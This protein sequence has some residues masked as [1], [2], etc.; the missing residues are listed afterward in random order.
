VTK[1]AAID[2]G[3]NSVRL[4]ITDQ[5]GNELVRSMQITRLGQGVDQTGA[6]DRA[7]MDRTLDVLREYGQQM[8]RSEVERTRVVAT[9][10]ARDASNRAAFFQAVAEC[11]HSEPELLSGAEEARLS[12]MGAV[13][14]F[15]L[16]LAPFVSFDIGGGSTEF[17]MGTTTP[18]AWLS[19]DMGCVRMSE[20]HLPS[21]PP[22]ALEL[23]RAADDV[24]RQLDRVSR[25]L[26]PDP[27]HTW[28]GLAGT[29]TSLAALAAG[30]EHYDP[31]RTHGYALPRAVIRGLY[32]RLS[33]LSE[34]ERRQILLEP[35]R[36]SVIV[37]GALILKQI[38]D[39]FALPRVLASERDILDG[40][41]AS[42]RTS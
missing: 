3:T 12:F 21:D 36:A 35:K 9:S 17:A 5:D 16:E 42:L 19:I 33:S 41:A 7:A 15:P 6:L 27:R 4:L 34:A 38:V 23:E 40:L 10:A 25:T 20:R 2:I 8:R 14:G 24:K 13:A 28:L 22:Q 30:L 26:Q 39:Y 1:L 29:V 31:Q 11:V 32:E 18:S 37:G